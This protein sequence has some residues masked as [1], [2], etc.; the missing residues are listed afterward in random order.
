[1]L[2]AVRNLHILKYHMFKYFKTSIIG[3]IAHSFRLGRIVADI[4]TRW[5]SLYLAVYK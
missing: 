2:V 4:A 5:F 1:M 3:F